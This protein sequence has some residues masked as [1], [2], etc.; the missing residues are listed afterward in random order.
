M[1]K[2][3]RPIV[4]YLRSFQDDSEIKMSARVANGR[5]LPERLIK[6]PFEEVVTD[7]LWGYGPVL[8]LVTRK[9]DIKPHRSEQLAITR[10]R[11]PGGRK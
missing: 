2:D 10:M 1:K 8:P 4:L 11:R 9:E 7:H 5:I 6:I 3:R